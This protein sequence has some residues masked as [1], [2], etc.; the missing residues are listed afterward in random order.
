MKKRMLGQGL[1][2]SAEGLGCM[3][4]SEIYG[5]ADQD[6]ATATIRRAPYDGAQPLWR[7]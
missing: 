4:M 5:S 7:Q 6:E 2:V 1:E 3:G